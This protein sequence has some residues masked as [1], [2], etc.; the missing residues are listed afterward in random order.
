MSPPRAADYDVI[1]A[2][3]G[4]AG[5]AAAI[6]SARRGTRTLVLARHRRQVGPAP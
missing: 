3:G 4:M 1:V 2:G 5:T 6:A